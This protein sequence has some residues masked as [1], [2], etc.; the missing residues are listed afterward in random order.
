MGESCGV[1]RAI[2]LRTK[3]FASERFPLRKRQIQH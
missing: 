1:Q 3:D 2:N